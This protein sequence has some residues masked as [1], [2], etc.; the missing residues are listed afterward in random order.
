MFTLRLEGD[1]PA[2]DLFKAAMLRADQQRAIFSQRF[3]PSADDPGADADGNLLAQG[4]AVIG[5]LTRDCL[6]IARSQP[7]II[8]IQL[9]QHRHRQLR[10]I[11]RVTQC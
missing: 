11:E 9:T 8:R 10:T 5:P 7:R 1:V 2:H 6:E 3:S 4:G